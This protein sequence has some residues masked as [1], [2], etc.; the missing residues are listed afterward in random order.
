MIVPRRVRC[1]RVGSTGRITLRRPL[2]RLMIIGSRSAILGA[3]VHTLFPNTRCR[4]PTILLPSYM[5]LRQAFTA[6]LDYG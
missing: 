6:V 3:D 5:V 2:P 4:L 1:L